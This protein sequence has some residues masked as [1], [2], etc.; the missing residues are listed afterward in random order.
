M[1]DV[2]KI[3]KGAFRSDGTKV[4]DLVI[5]TVG[6]IEP[7]DK[8]QEA[9]NN[10]YM[11]E[12]RA[13]EM[14][15]WSHLPGGVYDR[16]AGLMLSRKASSIAPT[17]EAYQDQAFMEGMGPALGAILGAKLPVESKPRSKKTKGASGPAKK[18]SPKPK[19]KTLEFPTEKV[20]PA[21]GRAKAAKP[22]PAQVPKNESQKP[23]TKRP[24]KAPAQPTKL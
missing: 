3:H 24:K 22:N 10:T 13:I 14:A 1:R 19:A 2:V 9:M 8:P 15:L 21:T 11:A 23:T 18:A 17:N 7:K 5:K 12:A 6:I 20:K 16:L 4:P